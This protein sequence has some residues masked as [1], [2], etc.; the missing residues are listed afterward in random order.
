M[1]ITIGMEE[2]NHFYNERI[3]FHKNH[4]IYP[5]NKN[6]IPLQ[7]QGNVK[8]QIYEGCIE[9]NWKICRETN[10]SNVITQNIIHI[11]VKNGFYSIYTPLKYFC[12]I[13][14]MNYEEMI[15]GLENELKSN[16]NSFAKYF[17][18]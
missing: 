7:L 3:L 14:N 6:S 8:V 13:N 9:D 5:V 12:E 10:T 18:I 11:K 15:Q 2:H 17:Y 16:I 1:K 4:N